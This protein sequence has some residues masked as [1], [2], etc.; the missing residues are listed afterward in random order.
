MRVQRY[1]SAF[2]SDLSGDKV[3]GVDIGDPPSAVDD[4]VG[5]DSALGSA[6]F[7]DNAQTLPCPLD[8]PNLDPGVDR[9]PDPLGLSARAASPH[10]HPCWQAAAAAPQGS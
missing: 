8:P 7:V 5:L 1:S 9:N 4:A 6:L 2:R 3:E 10:R